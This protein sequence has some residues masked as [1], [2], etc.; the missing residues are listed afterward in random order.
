MAYTT[1]TLSAR[2]VLMLALLQPF[3][4]IASEDTVES[5]KAEILKTAESYSGQG[6]PD[7]SKEKVLEALTQKLL[8]IAPQPPLKE[9]MLLLYGSWKQIFGPYDYRNDKRGVD[10]EI[11][12]DEIYQTV[13]PGG[14]YYNIS[15]IYEKG[16]RTKV[17]IGLL[18]GE[19]KLDEKEPNKVNVH[20]TRYPGIK[21]RPKDNTPLWKLPA[22]AEAE[23][24]P[25]EIT[26]VP[27]IIIWAFVGNGALDEVYTDKNMRITLGGDGTT[28]GKKSIY[29]MTKVQ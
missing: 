11:G 29:I 2:I 25:D 23:K 14:Y 27:R 12:T 5:L 8:K 10:P 13:F 19:Y 15:P 18:R 26:I 28:S 17:R 4:L 9:R 20:F 24:L 7:F 6:D 16:D 22:L 3:S 1:Y 21:G